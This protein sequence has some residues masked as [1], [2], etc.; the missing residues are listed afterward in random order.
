MHFQFDPKSTPLRLTQVLIAIPLSLVLYVLSVVFYRLFLHPYAKYSGSFWA[1]ISYFPAFYHAWIADTT[2][3]QLRCHE[4]YGRPTE[5]H[6]MDHAD[7]TIGAVVRYTPDNLMFL[8]VEAQKGT[9][10]VSV[11]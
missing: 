4:K 6:E 10:L 1:R 5:Y 9:L 3:H 2:K 11:L 7:G 8:Q